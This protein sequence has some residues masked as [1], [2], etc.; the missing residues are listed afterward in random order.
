MLSIQ[1]LPFSKNKKKGPMFKE[2]TLHDDLIL[3]QWIVPKGTII[4]I[5]ET[6]DFGFVYLPNGTVGKDGKEIPRHLF[7]Y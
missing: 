5:A 7:K 2:I 3:E 1:N 6:R 4:K